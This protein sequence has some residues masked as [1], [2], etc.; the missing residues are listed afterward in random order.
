MYLFINSNFSCYYFTIDLE[1]YATKVRREKHELEETLKRQAL[2]AT[3]SS[4]SLSGEVFKSA[5][6]KS[7]LE[8]HG[9]T[10]WLGAELL[11]VF[12]TVVG[13]SPQVTQEQIENVFK[14]MRGFGITPSAGV[15]ATCTLLLGKESTSIQSDTFKS[16]IGLD[17]KSNSSAGMIEPVIWRELAP[18]DVLEIK[19]KTFQKANNDFQQLI[20]TTNPE[21]T[22]K[23]STKTFAE[24]ITATRLASKD[25]RIIPPVGI[26]PP[27]KVVE[28][29]AIR[30][31]YFVLPRL[32]VEKVSGFTSGEG[33]WIAQLRAL[34]LE[35][36]ALSLAIDRKDRSLLLQKKIEL[37]LKSTGA[38]KS[39]SQDS[40]KKKKEKSTRTRSVLEIMQN[41]PPPP[42]G[43]NKTVGTL[44]IPSTA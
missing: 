15:S 23:L 5:A 40:K 13:S 18:T 12:K 38:E 37:T 16:A 34:G 6:K 10:P 11:K 41:P 44:V 4:S 3:S 14:T 17:I 28:T 42:K 33:P 24:A 26:L 25:V 43:W 36:D 39:T 31:D 20:R 2:L 7:K 27:D 22:K 35:G 1:R 8:Q 32:H 21:E 30:S 9:L 19:S 29:A